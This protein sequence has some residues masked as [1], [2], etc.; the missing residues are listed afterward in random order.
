MRRTT[1]L[2]SNEPP[3]A[4][5]PHDAA[6]TPAVWSDRR[7]RGVPA[8]Q[9][10]HDAAGTPVAPDGAVPAIRPKEKGKPPL[11]ARQLAKLIGVSQSTISRAFSKT[12]SVSPETRTMVMEAADRLGYRPN[13]IASILSK[14]TSNIVGVVIADIKSAIYIDVLDQLSVRMQALDIHPLL[15]NVAPGAEAGDQL[16]VLRQY[17]VEVVIVIS[18]RISNRAAALWSAGGRSVILINRDLPDASIG[19][20]RTDNVASSRAVVDHFWSLG[21]RR[22]AFVGGPNGTP[23][24]G[25]REAAFTQRI[26]ELG[27]TLCAVG[28]GSEY[29]HMAGY[30]AACTLIRARP[31]AIFFANDRLAIGGLDALTGKLGVRVPGDVSVVGFDDIGMARWPNIALTTVR[32]D[33]PRMIDAAM[34]LLEATL[35]GERPAANK[36]L[37]PGDLI[38]RSTTGPRRT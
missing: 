18:G 27:M 31:D 37:V 5:V 21:H 35:N 9:V 2:Q 33:V 11:T 23:T 8:A 24:S 13:F 30:E 14:R 36:H 28:G 4:Q 10:P 3:A 25:E 34:V 7:A 17:N 29:S 15:F 20:V 26:A 32:Q 12:A 1:R 6:G 19:S 16:D 38:L 22:V